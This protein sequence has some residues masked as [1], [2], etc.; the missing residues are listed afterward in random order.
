MQKLQLSIPEPCHENWQQMTPTEQGRFCNACAKEVIDFSTMTDIQ[1]LNYFTNLTHEKVCGRALP[2][3]LDKIISRPV[4]PKKK[5]F[6]YWNYFV[7]FVMFFSKGN[8]AKAQGNTQVV[9]V[10]DM[11]KIKATNINNTLTGKV[12]EV[13]MSKN[14]VVTGKVTDNNGNPVSFASIRVKGTNT[15]ISADAN[16]AY[17]TKV[18]SNTI[19]IISA[20]GFKEMEVPV[21]LQLSLTTILEKQATLGLTEIMVGGISFGNSDD[22]TATESK[23]VAVINVKEAETNRFIPNA[24]VIINSLSTIDTV[25]TNKKGV[26][27]IKGIKDYKKYF[28]KVI[29]DGYEPNEFTI[30]G[31]DFKDRKKEWEVLLKKKEIIDVAIRGT[32]IDRALAGEVTGA[33]V[34][35][36][37]EAKPGIQTIIRMGGINAISIEKGPI[38]I[39]DGTIVTNRDTINPDDIENITVLQGPAAAAL[40]GPDGSN[41]AIIIT[42][43]KL[44]IKNLDTVT[45][46]TDSRVVGRLITTTTCTT[47][48][49]GA[50]VAGISVKNNIADSLK[51]LATKLT[52]TIK[53]FPNPLQRGQQLSIA[54]K[55]KQAGFYQMQI[56]D[57]AGNIILKKQINANAKEVTEKLLPDTRWA[58]GL[59]YLSLFDNENNL[60]GKT[61][62][63]FE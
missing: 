2:E 51:M 50:S 57:A 17:S 55:L 13:S 9:T 22:Y 39:V 21:G 63:I 10:A 3:Q 26:H 15:G 4:Q 29:A 8:S 53:I 31:S 56:T 23:G 12:G 5:L 58:S 25:I 37:A 48:V 1:V 40:F 14:R 54:L 44:K 43:K 27:K 18:N 7:M 20:A 60:S 32:V 47:T 45:V 35:S 16:G 6:W 59:Y 11:N 52:G 34:R 49:M 33:V 24:F 46:T 30:D 62:F 38:Y 42:T 19:L 28:I 36:N 41:G 61:S